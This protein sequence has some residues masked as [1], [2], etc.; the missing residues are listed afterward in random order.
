MG[1]KEG[2]CTPSSLIHRLSHHWTTIFSKVLSYKNRNRNRNELA[3]FFFFWATVLRLKLPTHPVISINLEQ[4][5]TT[6]P[7]DR[8]EIH[9]RMVP[10]SGRIR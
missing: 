2:K 1:E 10:T 7:I 3:F 6:T 8:R 4:R 9:D 5:P